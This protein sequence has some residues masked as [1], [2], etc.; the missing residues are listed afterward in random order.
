MMRMWILLLVMTLAACDN[1][2]A[3]PKT[4]TES[5]SAA[6]SPVDPHLAT[7]YEGSC[8]ACHTVADALAPLT[9]DQVAWDPRW[10]KGE[11]ALLASAIGGI[12]GMPAG[13]QCFECTPGDL[14]ALIR[15]MA[16]HEQ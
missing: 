13:G 4:L 14:K 12:K 11:D 7:L 10:A 1:A 8:K 16:G 3:P 6:L 15:F 9:G 2:E 5:E